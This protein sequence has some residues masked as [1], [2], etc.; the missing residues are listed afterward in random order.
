MELV[1][2]AQLVIILGPVITRLVGSQLQVPESMT[3]PV[4]LSVFSSDPGNEVEDSPIDFMDSTILRILAD[5]TED[6]NCGLGHGVN[7][8]VDFQYITFE[9]RLKEQGLGKAEARNRLQILEAHSSVE[10][11]DIKRDYCY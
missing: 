4:L 7:L 5:A 6:V 3:E 11:D 10:A 8:K 9:K 2:W 1:C